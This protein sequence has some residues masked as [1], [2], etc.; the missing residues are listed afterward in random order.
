MT[1]KE[2]S[3]KLREALAVCSEEQARDVAD[4]LERGAGLMPMPEGSVIEF[5]NPEINASF[6]NDSR[7]RHALVN[8]I[9][10]VYETGSRYEDEPNWT[11]VHAGAWE[12][13]LAT[14]VIEGDWAKIAETAK[15]LREAND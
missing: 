8:L 4:I 3:R 11:P 13:V 14:L 7:L 2:A 12:S 15:E 9:D 6:P 1:K 10:A 5:G